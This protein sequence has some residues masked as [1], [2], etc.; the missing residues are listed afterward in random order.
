MYLNFRE[1]ELLGRKQDNSPC[2]NAVHIQPS[3][4]SAWAYRDSRLSYQ[5]LVNNKHPD[6]EFSLT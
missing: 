5:L 1:A 3:Q 4:I 6:T 2:M